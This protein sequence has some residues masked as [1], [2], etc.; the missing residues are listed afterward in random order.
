M[1]SYDFFLRFIFQSDSKCTDKWDPKL[2]KRIKMLSML[3]KRVKNILR[4]VRF[5]V[6][7]YYLYIIN[8]LLINILDEYCIN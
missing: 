3:K 4:D 1:V 2:F 7:C 5:Y 6:P 8:C